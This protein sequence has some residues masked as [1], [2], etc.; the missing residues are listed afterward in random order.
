M[1]KSEYKSEIIEMAAGLAFIISLFGWFWLAWF[2]A[3]LWS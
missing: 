3:A 1:K 2:A